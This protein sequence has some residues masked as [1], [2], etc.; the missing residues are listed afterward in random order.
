MLALLGFSPLLITV[1][2]AFNLL[3]QFA[4]HTERV[5]SLG[6]LEWVMNT[7][8]HHRVHHGRNAGVARRP[9]G[10]AMGVARGEA[11]NA[12]ALHGRNTGTTRARIG[13][14]TGA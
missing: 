9:C 2:F 8:S 6:P 13:R 7:P 10:C 11:R 5:R 1:S 14:T 12:R 4:V 3:Y